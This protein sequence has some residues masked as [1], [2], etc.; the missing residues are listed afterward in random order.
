MLRLP[1]LLSAL[2]EVT[3]LAVAPHVRTKIPG[4]L[5]VRLQARNPPLTTM[6]GLDHPD[7]VS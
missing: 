7:H 3:A 2:F 1:Y 6:L 4:H 5:T